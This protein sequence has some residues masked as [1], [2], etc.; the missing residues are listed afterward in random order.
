VDLPK[1]G[2][3]VLAGHVISALLRTSLPPDDIDLSALLV[4]ADRRVRSDADL[5]FFN[6]ERS[7]C[8]STRRVSSTRIEVNLRLVPESIDAVVIV[9]SLDDSVAGHVAGHGGGELVVEDGAVTV[10]HTMTGL[11][12]ERCVLAAELYRR[13]NSWKVRAISQGYADLAALI[14]AFGVDTEAAPPPVDDPRSVA[15]PDPTPPSRMPE[16]TRE[17]I[18]RIRLGA[19]AARA[20][21]ARPVRTRP[22]RPQPRAGTATQYKALQRA[23]AARRTASTAERIRA[24][25]NLLSTVRS[26]DLSA[27]A[28]LSLIDA[29]VPTSVASR[30]RAILGRREADPA[31][32][33]VVLAPALD[34][35]RHLAAS[36][37]HTAAVE[38][39]LWAAVHALAYPPTLGHV[40]QLGVDAAGSTVV[41]DLGLP[42]RTIVPAASAVR[43]RPT[44]D[45]FEDVAMPERERGRLVELLFA[46]AL[47]AHATGLTAALGEVGL[48]PDTTLVVNGWEWQRDPT[49]G[50]SAKV[51]RGTLATS[52]SSFARIDLSGVEPRA[53]VRSSGRIDEAGEVN[54]LAARG[55]RRT[56]RREIDLATIDPYE[57]EGLVAQLAEAMGH[58]ARR[59][60]RTRDHGVDV[61]VESNGLLDRGTIVI[62]VKR[63]ART[64]GPD[65][66]RALHSVVQQEGAMKGILIT[67]SGFGPES[68]RIAADKP[69]ELVDGQQLRAWLAEYLDLTAR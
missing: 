57:F 35:L 40:V 23:E 39:W 13:G 26:P 32:P 10:R 9:A 20:A 5:V 42:D 52:P 19:A 54:P 38:A 12:T 48:S 69:L 59:T 3:T 16:A 22:P 4:A 68:R 11:T 34:E 67:T 65:H 17:I 49:T 36:I 6:Q 47:L 28:L 55:R 29:S 37:G 62:S 27:G 33:A 50:H 43:Y 66:V 64:V 51:C 45:V 24:A 56:G 46:S 30:F 18:D 61:V 41:V 15:A 31:R 7:P 44:L 25:E 63:C 14:T 1:G 21:S 2:N 8:G 58:V 53:C 60:Q